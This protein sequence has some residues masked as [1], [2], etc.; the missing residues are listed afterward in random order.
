MWRHHTTCRGGGGVWSYCV[1]PGQCWH[2]ADAQEHSRRHRVPSAEARTWARTAALSART[3]LHVSCLIFIWSPDVHLRRLFLLK[4]MSTSP[5][6]LLKWRT[7]INYSPQSENWRISMNY[8][9]DLV[10]IYLPPTSLS[11]YF[12]IS[13]W[14]EK[15]Q[16]LYMPQTAEHPEDNNDLQL[17][18]K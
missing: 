12:F 8:L 1:L 10:S 4:Y 18:Q 7:F 17:Q 2:I 16:K 5:I 13:H 6:K 14:G 3:R 9:Q 11:S 15:K